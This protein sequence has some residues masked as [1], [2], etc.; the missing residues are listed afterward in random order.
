MMT[1]Y[2]IH[3]MIYSISIISYFY[4]NNINTTKL[5]MCHFLFKIICC[6]KNLT[7]SDKTFEPTNVPMEDIKA[8]ADSVENIVDDIIS[9]V[10]KV[11]KMV[12][13]WDDKKQN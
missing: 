1:K 9:P 8:V 6:N 11:K 3:M 13:W 2:M 4:L 10:P 5:E 12:K 7:D